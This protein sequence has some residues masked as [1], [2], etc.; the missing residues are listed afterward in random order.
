MRKAFMRSPSSQSIG[1]SSFHQRVDEAKA[2]HGRV[3]M[4]SK[5]I[6][7]AEIGTPVE[8]HRLAVEIRR[9]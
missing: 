5:S 1:S 2:M 9:R 7:F 6:G 4:N 8:C 3:P